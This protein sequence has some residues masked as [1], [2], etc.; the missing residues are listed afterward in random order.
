[1]LG[2]T[3]C[4]A[5]IGFM[6]RREY[7]QGCSLAAAL[8]RVGERWSLLIVRELSLGPLRFS[9][10]ARSVGGAPTDVLSAR[11]RTLAE[12]GIVRRRELD[13]P[14]AVTVYELT[15]LGRGLEAPMLALGRWGMALQTAEQVAGL[16][17]TSLPGGVRTL[18]RPPPEAE[19]TIGL[20]SEGHAYVLRMR[21]GW[22]EASRGIDPAAE[23]TLS[24]SPIAVLA[25]LVVGE[26]AEA[27]IEIEGD[28]ARLEDL[29][30]MVEL[31]ER[32]REEARELV[33]STLSTSG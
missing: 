11:L 33:V 32:L 22:I 15:E 4:P 7:G 19:M 13:Q 20:R 27:G 9:E 24:G 16:A 29:R 28:R 21:G 18:L 1:M 10:L 12:D 26:E 8:D 30:A 17:A 3:K 23:I 25:A 31:P 14:A 6:G 5:R 2:K